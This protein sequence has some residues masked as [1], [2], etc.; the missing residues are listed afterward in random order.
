MAVNLHRIGTGIS[1]G[2][3]RNGFGNIVSFPS[4]PAGFPAFGTVLSTAYGVDCE[5]GA[6]VYSTYLSSNVYSQTCDVN[7]VADG[8]GGSF[9]DW[10]VATNIQNQLYGTHIA[11]GSAIPMYPVEVPT[12]SGSFYNSAISDDSE[13]IHDGGGLA[14]IIP[15]G[16]DSYHSD[17]T[18]ITSAGNQDNTTQ[19]PAGLGNSYS[20]GTYIDYS[21]VWDGVGNFYQDGGTTNGSYHPAGTEV[22]SGLRYN[23]VSL[24]TE[25]PSGSGLYY[26]NGKTDFESYYWDGNGGAS[27][28]NYS[29]HGSFH[30]YGVFISDD[31]ID[32]FYWDGLGSY[33]SQP[34]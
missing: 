19:V 2:R 30:L 4:V 22:D 7:T 15:T 9:V 25:V 31:G 34:I 11:N 18:F 5:A 23:I 21:Y 14:I 6:T 20:N 26:T 33:F 13:E 12:S 28:G 27:D 10:G 16:F 24:E 8:V 1:S 17:G 32:N 29:P 3:S